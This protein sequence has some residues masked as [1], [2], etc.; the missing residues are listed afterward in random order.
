MRK[1]LGTLATSSMRPASSAAGLLEG[2]V[3]LNPSTRH[4]SWEHPRAGERLCPPSDAKFGGA[5][6]T[7]HGRARTR[8][9]QTVDNSWKGCGNLVERVTHVSHVQP[10]QNPHHIR[11]TS[12]LGIPRPRRCKSNARGPHRLLDFAYEAQELGHGN[13][14]PVNGHNRRDVQFQALDVLVEGH[15][16]SIWRSRRCTTRRV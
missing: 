7:C 2:S 11:R 1:G 12:F 13:D 6:I 15:V 8:V 16:A 5:S 14:A 4:R 9:R 10:S 3:E